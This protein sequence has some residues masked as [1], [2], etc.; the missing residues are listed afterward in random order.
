[1]TY[2]KK[3]GSQPVSRDQLPVLLPN[4][5]SNLINHGLKSAANEW[6]NT[7]CSKCNGPAIR[8][9]DTMDTFVD[10][11]WYFMRYIDPKNKNEMFSMEK[12]NNCLPVDLYI[13]G[14]EHGNIF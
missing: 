1:M 7:S 4:I 9:T 3:C 8:E 6:L 12:A 2:C 10:S 13:G 14:K 5:D 11:S